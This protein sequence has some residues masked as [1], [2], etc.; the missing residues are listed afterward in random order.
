LRRMDADSRG[1]QYVSGITENPGV[2]GS[3]PSL[4]TI[5]FSKLPTPKF[6]LD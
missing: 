5:V 6:S 1:W 3:I 2:G 4:P